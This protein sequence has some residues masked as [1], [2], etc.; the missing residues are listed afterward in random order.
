MFAVVSLGD[1]ESVGKKLRLPNLGNYG[2]VLG[3]KVPRPAPPW[4]WIWLWHPSASE[5]CG[6]T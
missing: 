4:P 6:P 2:S 1:S 5:S 3:A